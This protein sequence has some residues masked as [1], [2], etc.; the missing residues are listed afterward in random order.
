MLILLL[1][2]GELVK[3]FLFIALV[4]LTLFCLMSCDNDRENEQENVAFVTVDVLKIGKADCI[5]IDTG[6]KIL[7]IDT[8]EEENFSTISAYMNQKQ[9]SKI[10][11]LILTHYDKDHIGG[12]E[13]IISTYDVEN[14]IESKRKDS[15][16]EYIAYHNAIINKG[17]NLTKLTQDYEFTYDNCEFKI[18]IPR[19]DKY[20]SKND[21]NSSLI[22]SM[23]CQGKSLLFCGDAEEE[24][25]EE[26]IKENTQA[27]DLVKIPH[28]GNYL[29]NYWSFLDNIKPTYAVIT[30]SNKNPSDERTL[31][32]LS[33][34]EI[35]TYETKNGQISITITE[36]N[37][38]INQ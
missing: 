22:I 2:G 32:A 10:D 6:S 29:H 34:N 37:I 24:R 20:V 1:K 5:I 25:I 12:A 13:K 33:E 21:N 16:L 15:S 23:K 3:R 27:Y 17:V 8:G 11:T 36:N 30:C 4:A 19:K 26:F 35:S 7:M 28:H 31:K 9:Y 18:S 14:V 38:T